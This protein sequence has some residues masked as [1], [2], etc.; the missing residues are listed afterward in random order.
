MVRLMHPSSFNAT[1]LLEVLEQVDCFFSRI[2]QNTLL[3]DYCHQA[4]SKSS[5]S[6]LPRAIDSMTSN[7]N[8]PPPSPQLVKFLESRQILDFLWRSWWT[9]APVSREGSFPREPLLKIKKKVPEN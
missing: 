5:L 8:Y 4:T 1:R 9:E 2:L 3:E 6:L 7:R